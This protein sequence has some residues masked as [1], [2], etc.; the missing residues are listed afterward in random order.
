VPSV[1]NISALQE[2]NLPNLQVTILMEAWLRAAWIDRGPV[3]H[4]SANRGL[5]NGRV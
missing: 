1:A 4:T 3:N 2:R 5:V